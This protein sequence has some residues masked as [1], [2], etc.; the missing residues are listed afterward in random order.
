MSEAAKARKI[1][2]L[3]HVGGVLMIAQLLAS[4]IGAPDF[5]RGLV[6]GMMLVLVLALLVLRTRDD[7]VARLWNAGASVAFTVTVAL[8]FFSSVV[9][10]LMDGL[11]GIYGATPPLSAAS[12]GFAA[13]AAFFIAFHVEMLRAGR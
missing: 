11:A 1:L 8:T 4:F 2:F 12:V 7:Y 5:L 3:A 9:R 13:L 10:G 6:M